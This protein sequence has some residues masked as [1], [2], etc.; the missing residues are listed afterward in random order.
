MDNFSSSYQIPKLNLEHIDLMPTNFDHVKVKRSTEGSESLNM[1]ERHLMR[2]KDS[3]VTER[4]YSPFLLHLS[5]HITSRRAI[6]QHTD[7]IT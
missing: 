4:E 7:K 6:L 1:Y 3:N 5:L 2:N